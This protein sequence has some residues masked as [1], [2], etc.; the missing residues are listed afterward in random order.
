MIGELKIVLRMAI[1][2]V[3]AVLATIW[4]RIRRGPVVGSWSFS[5]EATVVMLRA[6]IDSA[7]D[8]PDLA[9]LRRVEARLDPPLPR[10]LKQSVRVEQVTLGGRPTERVTRSS[11]TDPT[12]DVL[13]L[14]G[15]GYVGGSPASHRRFVATLVDATGVRAWVLD[16]RLAP[17]YPFPAAVDDAASAYRELLSGGIEP[18]R[19]IVGGDS[20]GGGL[21]V[22]LLLRLRADGLSRPAGA[23]LFSPYV[24]LAHTGGSPER[25][26]ATDYVPAM[27]P[28]RAHTEYLGDVDPRTPQASPLYGDLAGLPPLLI[29]SGD[30]EAILDDSIRLH[31]RAVEHG[32]DSALH[33]GEDMPHVYPAVLPRHDASTI[34]IQRVAAWVGRVLA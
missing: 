2:I 7:L 25:N 3:L 33:L 17:E 10:A 8:T 29:V 11:G 24:D 27:K 23:L 32:V 26:A 6:G 34:A 28:G 13:Y 18:G 9:S 30:R 20:A 16:Y 21:A 15:G 22:A 1:A 4:R 19:L 5:T 14:H 12:L 31:D